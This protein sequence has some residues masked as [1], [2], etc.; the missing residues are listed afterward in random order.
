[1]M[2]NH[3]FSAAAGAEAPAASAHPATVQITDPITRNCGA[4]MYDLD[5]VVTLRRAVEWGCDSLREQIDMLG[6][7]YPVVVNLIKAEV[8]KL[9]ALLEMEGKLADAI[10]KN[11]NAIADERREQARRT[12]PPPCEASSPPLAKMGDESARRDW[13]GLTMEGVWQEAKAARLALLKLDLEADDKTAEPYF[14]RCNEAEELLHHLA[15]TT[16]REIAIALRLMLAKNEQS[17]FGERLAFEML[18]PDDTGAI[19]QLGGGWA[20]VWSLI[21]ELEKVPPQAPTQYFS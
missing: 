4:A 9:E 8:S 11:L 17:A 1:M 2:H 15:A 12:P 16:P 13:E 21:R 14:K 20:A 3:D 5:Q 10:M 6:E 7:G 19:A 18:P